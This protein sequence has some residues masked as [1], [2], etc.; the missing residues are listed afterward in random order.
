MRLLGSS[1][2]SISSIETGRCRHQEWAIFLEVV[3]LLGLPALI[4]LEDFVHKYFND[5]Q[6]VAS[7]ELIV[8]HMGSSFVIV[9]FLKRILYCCF[10]YIYSIVHIVNYLCR[11]IYIY[12]M[13]LYIS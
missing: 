2:T 10:S 7:K 4:S 12:D 11:T 9:L 6:D 8:M 5:T 13:L 1:K 3:A